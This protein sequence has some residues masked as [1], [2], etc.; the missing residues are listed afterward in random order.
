MTTEGWYEL[1]RQYFN[2]AKVDQEAS[3][4]PTYTILWLY[5]PDFT[6]NGQMNTIK[7]VPM[8][9]GSTNNT[10]AYFWQQTDSCAGYVV[11]KNCFYR[12]EEM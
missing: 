9:Q 7:H 3:T 12:Y 2:A 1:L 10:N 8:P 11:P 4:I 5:V 6:K